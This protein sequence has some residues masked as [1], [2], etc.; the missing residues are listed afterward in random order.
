LQNRTFGVSV[1]GEGLARLNSTTLK[2]SAAGQKHL[3][4]VVA[5][6]A[7]TDSSEE[8]VRQI[9]ALVGK[10]STLPVDSARVGHQ[11]WWADFWDRSYI[12][13]SGSPEAERV[14][15]G[16]AMQ[17]YLNACAGRGAFPIKVNGSIF[18]AGAGTHDPDQTQ[19]SGAYDLR[20]THALYRSMLAAGDFDL[21]MPLF[22]MY[23]EAQALAE[24]RTAAWFQHAGAFFPET[25]YLWGAYTPAAYGWNRQG[26]QVSYVEDSAQR[27]ETGANVEILQLMLDYAS[28]SQ[29]KTFVRGILPSLGTA[30]VDF[31]DNKER[32]NALRGVLTDFIEAK[33]PVSK[34]T[35]EK[36]RRMLQQLPQ[37][38]VATRRLALE[39][40]TA[41]LTGNDFAD[42]ATTGAAAY[43]LQSLLLE[44]EG[45]K[46]HVGRGWPAGWDADFKLWAPENTLVEGVIKAGKVQH[47]KVTPDKRSADVVKPQERS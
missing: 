40:M 23:R 4:T 16:Y 32:P 11:K 22:R 18:T 5:L 20:G 33:P 24:K 3:A 28:Y 1:Q 45:G 13:L 34:Q 31:F 47:L 36:A 26:R 6:T 7:V 2:S 10:V 30:I 38:E 25:M 8:W 46:L 27:H 37:G 17:R 19:G 21:A 41:A 14:A 15:A 43:A 12:K 29:D 35:M 44:S 39:A 42:H 9:G